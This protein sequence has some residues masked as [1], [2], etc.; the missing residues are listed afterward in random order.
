MVL[1]RFCLLQEIFA[2]LFVLGL[3]DISTSI[4]ELDRFALEFER[5][6]YYL[7]MHVRFCKP[8]ALCKVFVCRFGLLNKEIKRK[9]A[10]LSPFFSGISSEH[11]IV[12]CSVSPLSFIQMTDKSSCSSTPFGV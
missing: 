11:A 5:K 8:K 12:A 4:M 10:S 1:I 2:Q 3:E 9:F 7:E 6:V